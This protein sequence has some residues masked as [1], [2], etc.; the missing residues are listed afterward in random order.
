M[1]SVMST[2]VCEPHVVSRLLLWV[3][4]T[5]P[6]T[7]RQR[8][9]Q[10]DL[11]GTPNVLHIPSNPPELHIKPRTLTVCRLQQTALL[12]TPPDEV[13]ASYIM[14]V[15]AVGFPGT[16]GPSRGPNATWVLCLV[17]KDLF[18]CHPWY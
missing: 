11:P 17:L 13:V 1:R 5:Q 15:G 16:T 9:L 2:A 10:H 7:A 6:A 8:G 4:L 14:Q 12:L 3:N 18:H